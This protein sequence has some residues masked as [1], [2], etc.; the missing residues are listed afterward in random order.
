MN[1]TRKFFVS[2]LTKFQLQKYFFLLKS[3]DSIF[4]VYWWACSVDFIQSLC[5]CRFFQQWITIS[6]F[7]C[8]I[9]RYSR[10]SGANTESSKSSCNDSDR[11]HDE[12]R[13]GCQDE[14][15]LQGRHGKIRCVIMCYSKNH[16]CKSTNISV[17]EQ[18]C[19]TVSIEKCLWP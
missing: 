14:T 11:N 1:I 7:I 12:Q 5:E 9:T 15:G 13:S 4:I 10:C 8:F 16:W 3:V 18:G 19:G 2:K 17:K 6:I